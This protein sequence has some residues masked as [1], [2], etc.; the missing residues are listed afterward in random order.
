MTELIIFFAPVGFNSSELRRSSNEEIHVVLYHGNSRSD[1]EEEIASNGS[2]LTVIVTSYGTLSSEW[3]KWN[4]AQESE[5]KEADQKKSGGG[6]KGKEKQKVLKK[7]KDKKG[8][9]DVDWFRIVLDEAHTIRN[10]TTTNAKAVN[11][12]KGDRRWALTGTPIINR[13]EDLFSLLHFIRLEPWG[14]FAYFRTFITIPFSQ[15]DPKAIEVIAIVLESVCELS[16]LSLSLSRA[17]HES[18]HCLTENM[19]IITVLR[20]E[21]TT[22][23]QHGNPIVSLPPKHI[24][25]D[26]LDFSKDELEIY[27]AIYQNAKSKFLQY[28]RD[29]AVLTNVTAIFAILTRLR[30][31]V[32]HP[33]L[34]LKRLNL[35]IKE[36]RGGKA[37]TT[38]EKELD[39]E[40]AAIKKLLDR[41]AVGSGNGAGSQVIEELLAKGEDDNE[42]E[43]CLICNEVSDFSSLDSVFVFLSFTDHIFTTTTTID[44]LSNHPSLCHFVLTSDANHV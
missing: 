42:V 43:E 29:G 1:V 8:I 41:Y 20:R 32:L 35:N 16:V 7:R 39:A 9:F 40:D 22:K 34:V 11:A 15:K 28:E 18:D 12:L 38:E 24:S 44:S 36:R 4:S 23:D 13:L 10:R 25:A 30:Q 31:A 19:R 14:S 37:R 17:F 33:T 27:R 26:Y 5:A 2:F 21:K 6:S 3:S